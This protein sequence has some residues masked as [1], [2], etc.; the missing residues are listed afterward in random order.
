M[1]EFKMWKDFSVYI[2]IYMKNDIQNKQY[3]GI[4]IDV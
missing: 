1:E 3:K 4:L 2:Y